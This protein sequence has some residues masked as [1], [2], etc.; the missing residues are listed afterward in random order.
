V[1]VTPEEEIAQAN[2]A[3]HFAGAMIAAWSDI[4]AGLP[5]E[6]VAAGLLT[7]LQLVV[8]RLCLTYSVPPS[9]FTERVEITMQQ[10]QRGAS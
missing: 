5:P 6:V 7:A 2:M 8:A 4:T 9:L 1:S 10:L 3:Q